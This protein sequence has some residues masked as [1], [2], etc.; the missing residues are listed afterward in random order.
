MNTNIIAV[1]TPTYMYHP[2]TIQNDNVA[3][4]WRKNLCDT[5]RTNNSAN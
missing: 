3:S 1:V 2:E 5:N 4:A